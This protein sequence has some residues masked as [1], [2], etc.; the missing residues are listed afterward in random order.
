M[1]LIDVLFPVYL[2]PL[3]YICPERLRQRAVRGM[4]VSAP[5]KN[6]EKEGVI[7]DYNQGVD[8]ERPY[9]LKEITQVHN[10]KPAISEAHLK[11]LQW[12]G[13]YY[14]AEPGLVLRAML[15]DP[16][17][18]INT[19]APKKPTRQ[20]APQ[21]DVNLPVL[22]EIEITPETLSPL[23]NALEKKTFSVLLL[24]A[25]SYAYGIRYMLEALR[26]TD[27]AIIL[28]PEIDELTAITGHLSNA[29]SGDICLLHSGLT[30]VRRDNNYRAIVQGAAGFVA[31]SMT[32]VLAPLQRPSLIV[33]LDEHSPSYKSDKSPRYHARDV[34]VMRGMLEETTVLLISAT[35]SV[36][37]VYNA[38]TGRYRLIRCPV[39]EPRPAIKLTRT[40]QPLSYR[41]LRQLKRGTNL[42]YVNKKGYG[43]PMCSECGFYQTC[44]KCSHPPATTHALVL[45]N[46]QIG[47]DGRTLLCNR[48]GYK[49]T[50]HNFCPVCSGYNFIC[51]GSGTQRI[52]EILQQRLNTAAVR[53]D[54]DVIKGPRTKTSRALSRTVDANIVVATKMLLKPLHLHKHFKGIVFV[55]T[56]M[57]LALPQYQAMER[58]FQDVFRLSEMAREFI[59]IQTAMPDNPLHV[60]LQGYNYEGLVMHELRV[61]RE[62]SYPPFSKM[63]LVS[64]MYREG[65]TTK[66]AD[67]L[68]RATKSFGC[69]AFTPT[70]KGFTGGIQVSL[71]AKGRVELNHEIQRLRTKV[72]DLGLKDVRL[73]IDIDPVVPF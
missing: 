72:N 45:C 53:I 18:L 13:Q 73:D 21:K 61:R 64:V 23:K 27:S 58:L 55:G 43:I 69:V 19:E 71:R 39:Q 38:L 20:T 65:S 12:I 25:P 11:L 32:A 35:P 33:V 50:P 17:S 2:M 16:G 66:A 54:S 5:L 10:D 44:P 29:A 7:I 30:K 15:P 49:T 34:A 52:E 47:T 28:S 24:H 37:S 41:S 48:C 6:K 59:L 4:I 1:F 46:E 31:G 60:L 56:D 63:A 14:Y 22:S 51:L 3:T 42:V 62:L 9:I 57:Y 26:L 70:I 40:R 36:S 67:L 68:R 8:D